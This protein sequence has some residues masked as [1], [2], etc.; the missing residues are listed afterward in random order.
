VSD[1]ITLSFLQF[2]SSNDIGV[3][4]TSGIGHTNSSFKHA[5]CKVPG[6]KATMNDFGMHVILV[7]SISV[8]SVGKFMKIY[9]NHVP[10][11]RECQG[12]CIRPQ[13]FTLRG[14]RA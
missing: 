4:V 11:E 8:M 2:S 12:V 14:Q 1:T 9:L 13:A 7:T 6:V 10:F 5:L 3:A